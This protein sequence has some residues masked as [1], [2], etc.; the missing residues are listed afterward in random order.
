M[1]ASILACALVTLMALPSLGYPGESEKK[2]KSDPDEVATLYDEGYQ[3]LK[4]DDCRGAIAKFQAVLRRDSKHA[5]AYT[6][7][8]YCNRQLGKF[9]KA[10]RQ[11]KKALS[12][13]PELAEAHEYMGRAL[14]EVGDIETAK[15]HL[16]ILA[17]LDEK[18]A[19]PLA[20]AVERADYER[21]A[22]D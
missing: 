22:S 1:R 6:N 19:K 3:L 11:Y 13:D 21:G 4:A 16:E 15:A 12:I 18:L 9:K 8:A 2:D 17:R 5:M 14:L 20:D 10:I 7:M